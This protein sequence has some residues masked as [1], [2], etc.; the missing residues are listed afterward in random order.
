M[1]G[2]FE[3]WWFLE[4]WKNDITETREFK[5]FEEAKED[6]LAQWQSMKTQFSHFESRSTYLAAFWDEKELRW[7][8]ECAEDLQQYHSIL[9]LRDYELISEDY[10]N[11]EL[12]LSNAAPRQPSSCRL[13]I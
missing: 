8:E 1:F 6:Y 2:D 5:T 13:S 7:C 3:P 9:L 11:P 4:D 12:H 10:H